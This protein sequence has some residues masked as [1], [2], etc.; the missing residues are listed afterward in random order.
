MSRVLVTG[1]GG[2]IGHALVESLLGAGH[3]V[4][5]AGRRHGQERRGV[6]W[7]EVDLL[8]PLAVAAVTREVAA[9]GLVH[10]AWCTKPATYREAPENLDWLSAS[11]ALL[12]GFARAGGRRAVLG[13]TVFEYGSVRSVCSELATPVRPT[14]LYGQCKQSLGAI[15]AAVAPELGL[16]VANARIFWLYG[17]RERPERLVS[18]VITNLLHGRPVTLS[19]GSAALDI[20]HV[21]DVGAALGALLD[22]EVTGPVNIGS[23]HAVA[24]SE[25]AERIAELLGRAELLD[26]GPGAST[27]GPMVV[28]DVRRLAEEVG[29]HPEIDLDR[30]LRATVEWWRGT[31]APA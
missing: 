28:A 18:S 23:G 30:G 20:L 8:D 25:L 11:V 10:L 27:P 6:R 3:E 26:L 13:G 2:F 4:E 7:H 24:A 17:P 9:E 16:S 1:A 31:L 14:T 5:A 22:S 19:D 29:F 12:R 15:A 21:Q